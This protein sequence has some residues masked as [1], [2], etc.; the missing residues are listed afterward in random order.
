MDYILCDKITWKDSLLLLKKNMYA[1][2]VYSTPW[3]MTKDVIHLAL[4]ISGIASL[5]IL[6]P[7]LMN[8]PGAWWKTFCVVVFVP[9]SF[10]LPLIWVCAYFGWYKN[11][12]QINII[13]KT[14]IHSLPEVS[15]VVQY[16]PVAYTFGY[17]SYQFQVA[18]KE[19]DPVGR[20]VTVAKGELLIFIR[21]KDHQNRNLEELF[22][23]IA[24]F[25]EGKQIGKFGISSNSLLYRFRSKPLPAPKVVTEA[26]DLMLYLGQRFNLELF[27][28]EAKK[29]SCI[30]SSR[31]KEE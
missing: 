28:E 21:Y 29:S 31:T 10:M 6:I 17:K 8:P 23:E 20:S 24:G 16:M 19:T 18:F 4:S 12:K 2:R 27:T 14:F 11:I 5:A 26:M 25:L 15:S 9:L 13:L 30:S 7:A 1:Q 3:Q 22:Q